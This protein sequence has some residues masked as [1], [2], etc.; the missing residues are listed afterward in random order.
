MLTALLGI[1]GLSLAVALLAATREGA[2][3][4]ADYALR[5]RALLQTPAA[6]AD[7]LSLAD[8][9]ALPPPVQR[10]LQR[11]GAIGK[12]P[13]RS[14]HIVYDAEMFQQPGPRGLPGPAEQFNI[15][16]PARRLFFMS[17]R[18]FGLPVAV[19]HDYAGSAAS[20]RVRVARLF[21]VVNQRG[22]ELA[23]AETVTFLNDLCFWAPSSLVDPRFVWR[24]VDVRHADVAFTSAAHT[25]RATLVFDAAGDLVDFVS[26]DRTQLQADG[27]MQRL[28]WS[29]PMGEFRSFDGRRV[30][31]QGKAVWHRPEGEFVYGLF[32]LRS[33]R[34]DETP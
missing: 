18:M 21:D 22:D 23:R 3:L 9:A 31:T 27:T 28:R 7:V 2:N 12:P 4:A 1:A 17:S 6:A 20:M 24:A 34:F 30:P 15:V 5:R 10:Y 8:L 32:S 16:L 14:F 29:T 25:V 13:V 33:I 11:S 19:L 26:D